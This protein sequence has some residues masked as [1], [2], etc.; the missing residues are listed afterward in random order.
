MSILTEKHFRNEKSA[1]QYVE[2]IIWK[3]GKKCPHCQNTKQDKIYVIQ[4]EKARLGTHKCGTCK[5]QFTVK[6]G[7][8]FEASHIPLYK[9]IQA[10]FLMA[11]SKKGISAHQLHRTLEI[12]YKSAW[13]LAH[14]IRE[15][16]KELG[17]E[18][19]GGEDKIVESDET[20]IGNEKEKPVGARGWNHKNKILSLVER[21]GK[22]KSFHISGVNV[23][24]IKPILKDALYQDT[25]LITDEAT[26]YKPIG[27]EFKT[28]EFVRHS[29]KEYVKDGYIH[30]NTIEG[31]F[32]LFKRGMKGIYQHCK[33]Q[34]LKRYLCEFDF[35]YNRRDLNDVNRAVEIVANAFGKRL[36]YKD[37]LAVVV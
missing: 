26:W 3:D 11:S 5:K 19:M 25:N 17:C 4:S 10:C 13:F 1:I 6:I 12:T 9:W 30:T 34:H 2:N 22:V 16:M 27:K 29:A 32:G 28:H 15:A 21:Q 37:S 8:V 35:R 31:Y 36:K 23:A 24:T 33:S 14:R 18:K 20:F 7:T